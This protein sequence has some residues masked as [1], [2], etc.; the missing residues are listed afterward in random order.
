LTL[1]LRSVTIL[2]M[3]YLI[4]LYSILVAKRF[5]TLYHS[6]STK[7]NA[8]AMKVLDHY[9]SVRRVLPLMSDGNHFG[10]HKGSKKKAF[11]ATQGF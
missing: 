6:P 3:K 2:T 8:K 4:N 10:N 11:N 5:E 1:P 9:R 7:A